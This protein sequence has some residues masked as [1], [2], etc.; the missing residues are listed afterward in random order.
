[1]AQEGTILRS[2]YNLEHEK[3][4]RYCES[5]TLHGEIAQCADIRLK[6]GQTLWASKG[7]LL[8]YSRDI[9]WRLKV[10]GGATR[11]VSR[12][13]SGEGI[14]MTYVNCTGPQG[15]LLLTPNQPG[16]LA[17][18]DLE[19]G[20]VVCTRGA[21][22]AALGDADIDVTMAKSMG[23]A[24]FGGAGLLLQK[25]SGRGIALI[26][27]SGDFVEYQLAPGETLS[28]S[29]GNLAA[30]SAE[31]QYGVRYVGGCLKAIFGREGLFMTELT[32]PGWVMLQ[33]LKRH[34]IH[35][36]AGAG[37]VG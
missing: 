13:F 14:A 5:L 30:F 17:T 19:N 26:H 32:G 36:G 23:A 29:T 7:T 11:T 18:W 28:V 15:R 20:A 33:S 16:K 21:F 4:Q 8:S 10:P 3:I 35:A 34:S 1:M 22:V 25:L 37:A 24:F 12:A 31:V 27:G 9:D 6:Q 2:F